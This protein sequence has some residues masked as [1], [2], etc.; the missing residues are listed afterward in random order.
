MVLV[1]T[2]FAAAVAASV[3]WYVLPVTS[4]A[5]AARVAAVAPE[6]RV[7]QVHHIDKL[8]GGDPRAALEAW[9]SRVTGLLPLPGAQPWLGLVHDTTWRNPADGD[10]PSGLPVAY[11]DDFCPTP[12]SSASARTRPAK[13]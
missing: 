12:G 9:R 1:L 6:K 7:V 2:A 4:D 10:R 11:R 8:S 13:R 5:A 3:S